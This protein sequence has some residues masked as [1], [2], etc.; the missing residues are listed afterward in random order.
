M[1]DLSGDPA[2]AS[3]KTEL[4]RDLK[5]FQHELED[6]LNLEDPLRTARS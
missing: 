1:H 4:M 6:P 3:V 5:H 2:M